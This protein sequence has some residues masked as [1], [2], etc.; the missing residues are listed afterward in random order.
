M[1][2]VH[3]RGI[4]FGIVGLGSVDQPL[5]LDGA[6]IGGG[7]FERDAKETGLGH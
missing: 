6:A 3:P 5:A 1:F 4:G 2:E 7:A